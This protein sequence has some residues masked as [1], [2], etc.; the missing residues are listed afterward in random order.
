MTIKIGI[1]GA[2]AVG[3]F[4]GGHLINQGTEVFFLGRKRLGDEILKSG[5]T[6]TSLEG[7]SIHHGPEA[8]KWVLNPADLPLLDLII[9]TT[10]SQD[11]LSAITE[12]KSKIKNE[13]V[14]VSLQNG[15]SNP[16][17][18]K[19][20][21]PD[22]KIVTGMVLYNVIQLNHKVHFKQSSNGDI[23]LSENV[24]T[25]NVMG[26]K[27]V[28]DIIAIQWGKLLKNLNNALN[29]LSNRPLI[30]QLR[31]RKERRLL[32]LIASEALEVLKKNSIAVK[33]TS[34]IPI[35]IFPVA[36]KLPDSIFNLVSSSEF[37]ID[38]EA[39]LSMWQ[40]LELKRKTEIEYL[41]G[42]IVRM[43]YKS[44]INVPYNE[45]IIALIKLAEAGELSSAR[46]QYKKLVE[47]F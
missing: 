40:D 34:P 46:S 10:K 31:D 6:L 45:K 18:L 1:I 44:G 9:I 35:W 15:L 2:G 8:I 43:A 14:I 22:H 29:A 42:E 39:R 36:L 38:P 28:A 37:K 4:V 21:L 17:V 25:L 16:A 26:A 13:T 11:T 7:V 32:S 33:N 30:V 12:V 20:F 27:I 3:C 5:M 47:E 41:N 19:T 23:Y 24:D